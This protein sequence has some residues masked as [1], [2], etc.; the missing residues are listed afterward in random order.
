MPLF[1]RCRRRMFSPISWRYRDIP[2]HELHE[3]T[4]GLALVFL[5]SSDPSLARASAAFSRRVASRGQ[6]RA[7]SSNPSLVLRLWKLHNR[8][9][10]AFPTISIHLSVIESYIVFCYIRLSS[11]SLAKRRWDSLIPPSRPRFLLL[12]W[13]LP[14]QVRIS[15][16]AIKSLADVSE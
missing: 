11:I 12:A 10:D 6:C 3:R 1:W 16:N 7:S 8:L 15:V 5:V 4:R 14:R 2:P 9:S 13:N